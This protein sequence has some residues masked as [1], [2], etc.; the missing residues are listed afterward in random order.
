MHTPAVIEARAADSCKRPAT[1]AAAMMTAALPAPTYRRADRLYSRFPLWASETRPAGAQSL[2][3]VWPLQP[4]T[5]ANPEV[6]DHDPRP[7][8]PSLYLKSA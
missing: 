2:K 5:T 6:A 3:S 7:P 4:Q 1:I 8:K